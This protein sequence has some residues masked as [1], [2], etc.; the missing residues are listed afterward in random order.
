MPGSH[1]T[2]TESAGYTCT[3][4]SRGVP[5]KPMRRCESWGAGYTRTDVSRGVPVY[6][7]TDVIRGVPV[8]PAPTPDEGEV[9]HRLY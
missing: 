1:I 2:A 9:V 3:D 4:V 6:T 5:V 7:C 8:K